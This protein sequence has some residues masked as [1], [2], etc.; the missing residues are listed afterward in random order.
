MSWQL[1]SEHVEPGQLRQD[2]DHSIRDYRPISDSF[3]KSD[4]HSLAS[5]ILLDDMTIAK[6]NKPHC[7]LGNGI[8]YPDNCLRI[9]H[10]R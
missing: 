10:F 6:E 1:H 9:R 5:I 7:R 8:G 4:S 3:S 2:L